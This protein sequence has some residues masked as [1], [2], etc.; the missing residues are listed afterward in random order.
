LKSRDKADTER[1]DSPLI[2]ASD[3]RELDN[4][5]MDRETQFRLVLDWIAALNDA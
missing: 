3:A 1:A 2:A 5:S 4:S